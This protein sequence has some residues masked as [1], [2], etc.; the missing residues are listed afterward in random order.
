MKPDKLAYLYVLVVFIFLGVSVFLDK[1][2]TNRLGNRSAI[3]V[4]VA[5][6][7]AS[8]VFLIFLLFSKIVNYD[9]RGMVLLLISSLLTAVSTTAYYLLFA[10]SEISWAVPVLSLRAI[11]PIGLGIILLHEGLS[12]TKA[13]G[14]VLSLLAVVFLSL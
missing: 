1:L 5:Y 14:I 12:L 8:L 7:V 13:V 11:V 4:V 9:Q 3:P 2:A 10:R 6:L